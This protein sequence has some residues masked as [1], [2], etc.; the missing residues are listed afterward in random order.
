MTLS[1]A[2]DDDTGIDLIAL[3]DAMTRLKSLDERQARVVE[4][5][6]LAGM[7]VD[8][9]ATALGVSPRTVD[10]DWRL[11]RAWLQRELSGDRLPEP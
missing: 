5:R 7:T 4:L 6:F 10:A 2:A 3:D 1:G 8:E 9:S 11:A